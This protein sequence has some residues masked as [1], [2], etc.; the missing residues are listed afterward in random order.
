MINLQQ[1]LDEARGRFGPLL[2]PGTV[3]HGLLAAVDF[4]TVN[5]AA[6]PLFAMLPEHYLVKKCSLAITSAGLAMVASQWAGQR[7]S[8]TRRASTTG[9]G[10]A[11]YCG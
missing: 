11:P 10:A 1:T 9:D 5:A 3:V 8:T 6:T 7:R 4:D 2:P